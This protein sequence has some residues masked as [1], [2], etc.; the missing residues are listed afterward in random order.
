MAERMS[1]QQGLL[2]C[3]LLHPAPFSMILV[4]MILHPELETD[5][6]ADFRTS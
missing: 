1:A 5:L 3:K 4:S 6:P 2:L